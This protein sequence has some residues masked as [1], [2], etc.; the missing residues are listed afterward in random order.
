[1]RGRKFL[2]LSVVMACLQMAIYLPSA[3][4]EKSPSDGATTVAPEEFR[5]GE[6]DRTSVGQPPTP[7]SDV[8]EMNRVELPELRTRTGRTFLRSDGLYETEISPDAIHYRDSS[9]AWQLIDNGLSPISNGGYRNGANSYGVEFP[10]T[11]S[12]RPI[13]VT[14]EDG[15]WVSFQLRGADGRASSDGA[16]ARYL[17]ALPG[18]DLEYVPGATSVKEMIVLRS[19]AASTDLTFDLQSSIGLHPVVEREAIQFQDDSG[20]VVFRIP[21]PFMFDASAEPEGYSRDIQMNLTDSPGGWQLDVVPSTEWLEDSSRVWP[22]TIDP[23]VELWPDRDCYIGNGAKSDLSFFSEDKLLV[24]N[25]GVN[26]HRSLVHFNVAGNLPQDVTVSQAVLSITP[27]DALGAAADADIRMHP[28]QEDWSNAVTWNRR[29]GVAAWSSAGGSF[30][31]GTP[32]HPDRFAFDALELTQDWA[33]GA[34]PNHGVLLKEADETVIRRSAFESSD[35]SLRY[36]SQLDITYKSRI[37]DVAPYTFEDFRLNDRIITK[38]N[39]ASG[40]LVLRQEDMRVRGTGIDAVFQRWYNSRA[41]LSRDI[42]NGPGSGQKWTY[43]PALVDIFE[44]L[45]GNVRWTAPDGVVWMFK[46]QADGSFSAPAGL[47]AHLE[48]NGLGGWDVVMN[49]SGLRYGGAPQDR[50]GNRLDYTYDSTTR[51]LASITDTQGRVTTVIS[52]TNGKYKGL[53]TSVKDPA[54]RTHQY[55]YDGSGNLTSYT[56]PA[57]KV[58]S[59]GYDN[60]S[61]LLKVTTPGG[62]V[63]QFTYDASS[64]VTSVKRV[65]NVSTGA[66]ST[67][68]FN[69]QNGTTVVTDPRNNATTYEHDPRDRVTKVTDAQGNVSSKSYT[70]NSNVES[71]TDAAQSRTLLSY[72]TDGR[73]NLTGVTLPTGAATSFTYD[74]ATHPYLTSSKTDDRGSV[75]DYTYDGPGNLKTGDRAFE[76]DPVRLHLQ[77]QRHDRHDDGCKAERNLLRLRHK[78]QPHLGNV[79]RS[80]GEGDHD[81]RRAQSDDLAD[82]RQGADQDVYL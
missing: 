26:V 11:L 10:A 7:E 5:V 47:H 18:V 78:G 38:V 14:A 51:N 69:Y 41:E 27:D 71:Y 70:S 19:A 53:I 40:N 22:V 23:I 79:S 2:C 60:S 34:R 56:D 67:W 9:G 57:S 68:T 29:D 45:F 74:D 39:V 48:P 17:D 21:A 65:S 3:R 42:S 36:P 81:L 30:G 63:T 24:G 31:S 35:Q 62:D 6:I 66:G 77:P 75:T 61:N 58:T 43:D 49:Q 8:G 32:L 52:D 76:R 25:D 16:S 37:G 72:S 12:Q 73:N 28:L 15:R 82:R 55:G 80:T 64:R 4:A 13:T 54:A 50:N 59:Y 44:D 33:D 46:R 1:M 20:T